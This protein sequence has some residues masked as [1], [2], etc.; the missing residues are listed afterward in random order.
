MRAAGGRTAGAAALL[1]GVAFASAGCA[2]R[3]PPSGGPPDIE[4]P[5]MVSSTPDSGAAGIAL[6]A[7]LSIT[8]SEG[9]EPRS[10]EESVDLAPR[11]AI[12]KHHWSA[13][14]LTLELADSLLPHH[15][16]AL[17]VR[18]SARDRHGNVMGAGHTVV[19]STDDSFP[20]GRISGEVEAR[21]M[22]AEATTLWCYDQSRKHEPDSTARDFDAL[23]QV[24]HEGRFSIDGLRV[25]GRY[26]LWAFA[27]INHNHSFEPDLDVL[28][29][30]DTTFDLTPLAPAAGNLNV[31]VINPRAPGHVRGTVTD[32]LPDSLGVL[33]VLA[34]SVKDSTQ[35][36]VESVDADSTFDIQLDAGLWRVRA[37]RDLN[38]DQRWQPETE[39]ASDPL[40]IQVE[41]AA[42]VVETR[43]ILRPT[44]GGP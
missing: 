12:R 44:L 35:R 40:E 37:F 39:R 28:A 33:R 34:V 23:G 14:T 22:A 30:V 43:L 11:I 36:V 13:R 5:R 27:D 31:L 7:P 9:M 20:H 26:R 8:F 38:K 2:K 17:F 19:F 32:S 29:P 25:P 1:L 16:Y 18:G 4:P 42:D 41:P 15:T 10:T 6:D 21:G 3:E 24:D